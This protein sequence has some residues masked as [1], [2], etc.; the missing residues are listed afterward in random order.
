MILAVRQL[1]CA[2]PTRRA[3][4]YQMLASGTRARIAEQGIADSVC[5]CSCRLCTIMVNNNVF[6]S[7]VL[8][9]HHYHQPEELR[10][11]AMR[12]QALGTP[13]LEPELQGSPSSGKNLMIHPACKIILP[14]CYS[15]KDIQEW[16]QVNNDALRQLFCKAEME[17]ATACIMR[18]FQKAE[19]SALKRYCLV[20]SSSTFA[21]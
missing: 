14:E 10:I 19:L 9:V 8:I 12:L 3:Q 4:I 17:L 16:L 13:F 6:D 15:P 20:S 7:F 2:P 21:S 1:E 18:L 5:G 11:A